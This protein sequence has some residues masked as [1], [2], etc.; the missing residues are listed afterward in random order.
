[1]PRIRL[2]HIALLLSLLAPW[3]QLIAQDAGLG[4]RDVDKI[5]DEF[6]ALPWWTRDGLRQR[7]ALAERLDGLPPLSAREAKSW[8]KTLLEKA[9][10]LDAKLPKKSGKHWFWED[11]ERGLYIVGGKLKSPKGLLIGM[12][13]GGVGSGDAWS[14]HGAINNAAEK[15]G[16]V[17]IFPQVLELTEHGWTDAGTEEFVLQLV[18][19]ARR[20]WKIDP[21]KVYFSGHSMG[22][23]GS[24]T[25]GAHHAD[26]VAALAPSAGAPTPYMN[27]QGE[28]FDIASGVV[29]S[30]RNVP[31]VIYQS[32]DDPQVPADA[33]QLAVSKLAE[34]ADRWGG[35]DY[36]YW[37]VD[38]RGHD[39]PPGGF[40]A[41]LTKIKKR[42]REPLPE[43]LVWQPALDWK[44][45]FHW[46]WWQDPLRD[47]VVQADLDGNTIHVRCDE[48][49]EGLHV[50]LNDELLDLD[51]E[52]VV[53]LG[54]D[55]REVWRGVPERR[56]STLL[57]TAARNDAGLVFDA[58]VP[59]GA[60]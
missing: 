48:D 25:L 37:E 29:P 22:G 2:L 24:W 59:V 16:W 26:V 54:D 4:K 44:R 34:A 18:D 5:V 23:Y 52:V 47:A 28:I 9:Q 1:M 50:L 30:L 51:E 31:M 12:H 56:L 33:N 35:Y 19:R 21:D 3:S 53:L 15:M 43:R 14:A 60:R 49:V 6:L 46:L 38:G 36:E 7:D 40:K 20:T 10:K 57:R 27:A 11:E 17:A 8:K 41:L 58:M 13:G 42:E 45:H 32:R 55:A 39:Y